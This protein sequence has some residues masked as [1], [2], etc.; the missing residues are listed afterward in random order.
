MEADLECASGCSTLIDY[1][2]LESLFADA[3]DGQSPCGPNLDDEPPFLEL[4][5]EARGRPPIELGAYRVDPVLPDWWRLSRLAQALLARSKD[6]RTA[7]YLLRALLATEGLPGL[8]RGLYVLN[9]LVRDCWTCVHPQLE[10]AEPTWR[11]NVLAALS[12]SDGLLKELQDAEVVRTSLGTLTVR[13]LVSLLRTGLDRSHARESDDFCLRAAQ[14]D[15]RVLAAVDDAGHWLDKLHEGLVERMGNEAAVSVRRLA[16][17]VGALRGLSVDVERGEREGMATA[18]NGSRWVGYG[19]TDVDLIPDDERPRHVDAGTYFRVYRPLA[20]R[21]GVWTSFLVYLHSGDAAAVD[22]DSAHRLGSS[23]SSYGTEEDAARVAIVRGAEMTVVPAVPGCR[24][25]PR[26][27]RIQW[28]EEIHTVEF[29]LQ[30]SPD[31]AGYATERRLR[32]HVRIYVGPLLVGEIPTSI[33]VSQNM[34]FEESL[35]IEGAAASPF[36]R[37]FVSYSHDDDR[38][39]KLLQQAYELVRIDYLRDVAV[40]RAGDRW[41]SRILDEI[42]RAHRFQLC[43]SAAASRSRYV[44]EEWRHALAIRGAK[45]DTFICPFYWQ[46]PMPLPP[47][48]LSDLHFA[49][50]DFSSS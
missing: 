10:D 23:R 16:E 4:E 9:R 7:I 17:I 36:S 47:A 27:Q 38:I 22:A 24:F 34:P 40:L 39:V 14:R 44:E 6:L 48:E 19:G 25:N 12:D 29:R 3:G 13:D 11:L 50:F 1:T 46:K 33:V 8:A 49:Y 32:G 35:P 21:P 42:D 5:R 30:A 41:N 28:L 31:V 20:V 15:E 26:Q 45:G 37:V 2:D 43:W 18:A